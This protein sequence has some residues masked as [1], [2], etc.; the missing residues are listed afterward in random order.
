[1]VKKGFTLAE[2]LITLGII[3]VVAALTLPAIV[4]E[5]RQKSLEAGLARFY[6]TINQAFIA[7]EID[8][9]EQRYWVYNDNSCEFFE[10]YLK[11]YLQI[12]RY[13]CGYYNKVSEGVYSKLDDNRFVGIYF[14]SGDMAV[15][16]YGTMFVYINKAHKYYRN[17]TALMSSGPSDDRSLYGTLLFPFQIARTR[18]EGLEAKDGVEPL[19][20]LKKYSDEEIRQRC[21]NSPNMCVEMIRRNGWKI[22]KDYPYQIK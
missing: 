7:S 1:M 2:V 10:K 5:H 14:N 21:I 19:G 16:S 22:P 6:S 20:G 3:G 15:F 8:N 17:Y 13:E 11:K 9:G 18:G 4:Q 12:T